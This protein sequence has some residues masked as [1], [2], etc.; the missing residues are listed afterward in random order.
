[1]TYK[2]L[3]VMKELSGIWMNANWNELKQGNLKTNHF[4]FNVE[5]F[6]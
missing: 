2:E 5:K 4:S 6:W 1:M 3:K